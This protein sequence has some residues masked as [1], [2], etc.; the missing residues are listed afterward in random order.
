M[1]RVIGKRSPMIQSVSAVQTM[2]EDPRARAFEE[3]A[4]LFSAA[5]NSDALKIFYAAERGITNST[6]A[7]KEMGLTQKRY[8]THLKRLIDVGLIEKV[9]GA[10]R[11]TTLGKICYKMAEAL[12]NTLSHRG[13]LDLID[14]LTKAKNISLEESEEIMRAILKDT[15]IVP[16]ERLSDIIGPVKMADTWDN[17]VND[18]VERIEKAKKEIFFASKYH[19]MRT[20]DALLKAVQRGVEVYLLVDQEINIPKAIRMVISLLFTSPKALS[21]FIN[22]L[23]S[24]HFRVRKYENLLYSFMVVDGEYSMVEILTPIEKTFSVAFLFYNRAVSRKLS[25]AFRILWERGSKIETMD[26]IKTGDHVY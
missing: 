1:K 18:V 24:P 16:G 3:M 2:K 20:S 7:I 10:Y 14:K 19:E 22:L 4:K 25:D 8:Y 13:R 21:A 6:R 12:S 26:K 11:H 23:R 9:D 17:L 15:N 5:A